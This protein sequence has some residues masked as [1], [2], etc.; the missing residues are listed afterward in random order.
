MSHNIVVQTTHEI[1][2]FKEIAMNT[3]AILIPAL[4]LYVGFIY[5]LLI[6][7]KYKQ[8]WSG[9][10]QAIASTANNRLTRFVKRVLDFF[11][12]LLST[13]IV[14]W[15]LLL[16]VMAISQQD[17]PTWGVDIDIFSGFKIDLNE[18][19]GVEASGLRNPELSGKTLITID[20]SNLF[21]WYLYAIISQ[22][23]AI[24][25]LYGLVQLRA[26]VIS[27]LNGISFSHANVE[28]IKKLGVLLIGWNIINPFIQYF[29]WGSVV[30]DI[31]F[32]QPGIQ[33]YPAFEANSVALFIG[34][35]MILLSGILREA[36]SISQEQELTI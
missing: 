28:R 11:M 1:T 3:F 12:I 17:I 9:G 26:I 14:V 7:L 18:L 32:N 13:A 21:A 2:E 19:Q 31:T 36:T 23:T 20:T 15:P 30:N 5:W 22:L 8:I 34:L 16:A 33:M 24:V 6:R 10:V 27:L 4:L 25:S 29:G 35:M